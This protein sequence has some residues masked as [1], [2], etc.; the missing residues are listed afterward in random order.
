[1][2]N[3]LEAGEQCEQNSSLEKEA[4]KKSVLELK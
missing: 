1:M 4:L 3:G 2:Q